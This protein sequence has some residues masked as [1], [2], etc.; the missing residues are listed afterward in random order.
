[1]VDLDADPDGDPVE[2]ICE[3]KEV[4]A[5]A[6]LYRAEVYRS[7]IWRQR[8]DQTMN[9]AVISTGIGLSVSFAAP[10]AS[11]FP[12]VL[13]GMLCVVF[14]FLEARRYRF[15]YVWRFRA[16]VL[17][18]AFFVPILQGKGANIALERGTALS[19][20]YISP[21]YRISFIRCLGR[22]LRRNYG[23]IFAIL[24]AAYVAKI[25]LMLDARG[26]LSWESFVYAAHVGPVPGALSWLAGAAFHVFWITVAWVTWREEQADT[27]KMADFLVSRED[28]LNGK[29]EP[30][31]VV[32][33]MPVT[34]RG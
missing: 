3:S 1:M 22:R 21:Q 10:D 14:L 29:P 28:V 19:D 23:Y 33:D 30:K 16:R 31:R 11:A 8:L 4:G 7:T 9:W 6:H 27:G 26:D 34:N 13:V 5:L 32:D 20:D 24:G 18:I 2:A 25:L 15:F 12:I 17:E